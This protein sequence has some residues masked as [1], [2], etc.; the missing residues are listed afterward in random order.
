MGECSTFF[1]AGRG[2]IYILSKTTQVTAAKRG[3]QVLTLH[4]EFTQNCLRQCLLNIHHIEDEGFNSSQKITKNFKA[5]KESAQ[6]E[7]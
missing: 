3:M 5:K 1:R 6:A 7:A 4:E 2:C